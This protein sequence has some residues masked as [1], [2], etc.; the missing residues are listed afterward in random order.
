MEDQ[1]RGAFEKF[2][3]SAYYAVYFFG[4][5]V[6]RCKKYIA[7]QGRYFE[8]ETVTS[9]PQ[10]SNSENKGESTN[11]SNSPRSFSSSSSSSFLIVLFYLAV[12][13]GFYLWI[14]ETIGRT[15]WKGN[16][17]DARLLPTHR[18]TQHRETQTHIHAPSRIRTWDLNIWATEDCTCLRPLGYW[19]RPS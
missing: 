6:E 19:D 14:Y 12:S 16:R 2:V 11:F 7:C 15:P 5:L 13:K 4:K 17:P 1:L 8:K 18:T 10:S 3:D 9:H